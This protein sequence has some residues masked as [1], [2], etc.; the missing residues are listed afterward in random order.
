MFPLHEKTQRLICRAGFFLFCLV[1]TVLVLCYVF[2]LNLPWHRRAH[3]RELSQRLGL[4][5]TLESVSFP[6]P[7]TTLYRG[8]RLADPE[9]G[10]DVARIAALEIRHR[11]ASWYLTATQPEIESQRAELLGR[12][13]D[14][15]VLRGHS[16]NR[17]AIELSA[18]AMTIGSAGQESQ[19]LTDV[20]LSLSAESDGPILRADYR[21]AGVEMKT[22]A[23]VEIRRK[24]ERNT[25]TTHLIWHTGDAALPCAVWAARFPWIKRLGTRCRFRGQAELTETNN[26]WH[27]EIT[28]R[29]TGVDLDRVISDQFPHKLSG[30]ATI[31]MEQA[32]AKDGKLQKLKGRLV[33][34]PGVVGERLLGA[35]EN[36]LDWRTM[37]DEAIEEVALHEY[38]QLAFSFGIDADSMKLAGV[39]EQQPPGTILL[40]TDGRTWSTHDAQTIPVTHLLRVLV[41][42]SNYEIPATR[43]T[44]ALIN[45]LPLPDAIPPQ[46]DEI[47]RVHTRVPRG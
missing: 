18:A 8:L 44:R 9:S 12:L 41:P 28:G 47:P 33:A 27:G 19:T 1:P 17:P 42:Q 6:R 25:A 16:K 24:R 5:A 36:E 34:G 21:V 22:A 26:S 7:G 23:R 46:E 3:E 43:Q 39:C 2:V 4:V 10:A 38:S 35:A 15:R 11:A 30:E 40:A 14:E 29:L 31:D 20:R 37:K 45:F 32:I 13:L